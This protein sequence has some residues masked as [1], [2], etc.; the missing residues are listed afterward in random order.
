MFYSWDV[1]Y[2][3]HFL[4][5]AF[6]A[7]GRFEA[8]DILYLGCFALGTYWSLGSLM[9]GTFWSWTMFF[10]GILCLEMFCIWDVSRLG[11]L[12]L[13]MFCRCTFKT[14]CFLM[15]AGMDGI[16]GAL[17][18]CTVLTVMF[19]LSPVLD[20]LRISRWEN[21]GFTAFQAQACDW[22][23]SFH[24]AEKGEGGRGRF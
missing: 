10:T 14:K 1:L 8:W 24:M 23:Y 20:L 6:W 19:W 22:L 5:G 18:A 11:T 15:V 4:D 9:A 2:L 7:L 21:V 17:L 3:G 13:G 16:V 12:C